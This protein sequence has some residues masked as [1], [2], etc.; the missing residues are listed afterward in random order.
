MAAIIQVVEN[1]TY[2]NKVE[3]YV[4]CYILIRNFGLMPNYILNPYDQTTKWYTFKLFLSK[5]TFRSLNMT[6]FKF[7]MAALYVRGGEMA[8]TEF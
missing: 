5:L 2:S 6:A 8:R 7:K 4:I 3:K 1:A